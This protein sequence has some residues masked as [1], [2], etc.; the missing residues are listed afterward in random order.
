MECRKM[1]A[2]NSL[3]ITYNHDFF[4]EIYKDQFIKIQS[5]TRRFH[6]S[7]EQVDEVTQTTF[8]KAWQNLPKLRD[9]RAVYG[10]LKTI[11]HNEYLMTLNKSNRIS[12]SNYGIEDHKDFV[13]KASIEK[14]SEAKDQKELEAILIEIHNQIDAIQ[15]PIRKEILQ[16]HL[17]EG[18]PL[19]KVSELM[20][21]N[22]NTVRS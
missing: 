18:L 21:L 12:F 17:L 5:Q 3:T 7:K 14:T 20:D 8:M 16:L 10:W 19:Q 1:E 22:Y 2:I 11:C 6:F 9:R 15:H 13:E 4:S